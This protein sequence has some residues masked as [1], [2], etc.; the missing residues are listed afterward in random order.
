MSGAIK[1][2]ILVHILTLYLPKNGKNLPKNGKNYQKMVIFYIQQ[3][4]YVY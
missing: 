4:T 2:N 3:N 1:L